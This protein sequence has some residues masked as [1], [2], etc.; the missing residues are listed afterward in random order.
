MDRNRVKGTI[1]DVVGNAKRHI[2]DLTGSTETKIE[3]TVQQIKGKVQNAW[4]KTLDTVRDANSSA[5]ASQEADRKAEQERR[6]VLV[7]DEADTL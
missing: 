6:V 7:P 1:N 2:G 4:G 5:L 3:G